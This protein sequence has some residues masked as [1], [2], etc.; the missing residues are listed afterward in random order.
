MPMEILGWR[1]HKARFVD[2]V[3]VGGN[4]VSVGDSSTLRLRAFDALGDSIPVRRVEWR[5]LDSALVQFT[6]SA[7][8]TAPTR[9]IRGL[10]PDWRVLPQHSDG[11]AA[12]LRLSASAPRDC[13]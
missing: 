4:D 10:A 6:S 3:R 13:H 8:D 12:I 11:G 1:G 9:V 7:D 2:H 5:A